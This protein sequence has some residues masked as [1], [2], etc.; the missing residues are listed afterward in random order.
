MS[1]ND[2]FLSLN[3]AGNILNTVGN[4]GKKP[5]K[6]ISEAWGVIKQI[7]NICLKNKDK[8]YSLVDLCSGNALVPVTAVHLFKNIISAIAVD[9][10]PRERNWEATDDFMYMEKDIF[11]IDT[12]QFVSPTILTSIHCCGELAEQVIKIFNTSEHIEHLVLMPCC[13]GEIS[14]PFLQFLKNH[15]NR[16]LAWIS[17]LFLLCHGKTSVYR[18]RFILSPKDYI[19]IS[20]KEA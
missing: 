20:K 2:Q 14:N 12:D 6:E 3:A 4:I 11:D 7:R 9:K 5:R 18:D 1:Y 19:L 15:G 8:E 17:K 13:R 16:D 10:L